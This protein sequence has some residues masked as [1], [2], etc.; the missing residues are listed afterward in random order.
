M[1]LTLPFY[2][3][4]PLSLSNIWVWGICICFFL[5]ARNI[6]FMW[7]IKFATAFEMFNFIQSV[8]EIF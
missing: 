7:E 1:F 8:S 5:I 3:Y 4:I 2:L 6:H